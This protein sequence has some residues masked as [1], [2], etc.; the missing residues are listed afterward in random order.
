MEVGR[1]VKSFRRICTIVRLHRFRFILSQFMMF[2]AALATIGYATLIAPL[3][4]EGMEAGNRRAEPT[5]PESA[6]PD[7]GIEGSSG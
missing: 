5:T 6:R 3:V 4:N 7:L 1:R 2:V